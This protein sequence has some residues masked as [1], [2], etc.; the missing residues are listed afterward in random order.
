MREGFERDFLG[1]VEAL[2]VIGEGKTRG[3]ISGRLLMG[4]VMPHC[5]HRVYSVLRNSAMAM[6]SIATPMA[7]TM[8]RD[9]PT[10]TTQPNQVMPGLRA[11]K[12]SGLIDRWVN[13]ACRIG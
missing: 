12:A 3:I 5:G 9:S 6:A 13:T 8:A 10:G 2:F 4:R 11:C 1:I 7:A